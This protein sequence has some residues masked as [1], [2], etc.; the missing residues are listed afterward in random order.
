MPISTDTLFI[1][2]NVEHVNDS[3]QG[4][5]RI[6]NPL[7]TT[8]NGNSFLTSACNAAVATAAQCAQVATFIGN[9]LN[10]R[11][12]RSANSTTGFVRVDFR[13]NDHEAFT[14]SAAV[15]SSRGNN[16]YNNA[17]VATNGGLV[18]ANADLDNTTRYAALG[19]T[20]VIGDHMINDFHGGWFRDS[21]SASTNN[22]QFPASSSACLSCGTGPLGV[23]VDG[24]SLGGNPLMP[25]SQRETRYQGADSFT[26][27]LA[28]HTIRVGGDLWRRQDT[29]D[30]LFSRFG[31]YNYDSL[32]AFAQDFSF[33]V[34][35]LK[36]YATY[37][38]TLGNSSASTTDWLL[39][40][41]AEDTWQVK[42]GFTVT[43]GLRW[44]KARLPKPTEPSG[45]YLTG[46]IPSPNTDVQPRIGLAYMLDR[47]TVVRIGGG[48]YYE[49]FPGQ[50]LHDL[51]LGG[52]N[53]QTSYSLTPAA[54]GTVVF[55]KTL[56]ASAVNTLN[57]ALVG[58]F[59]AAQRFRNPYSLQGSAAIERRLNRWVSL[60]LTYLQSTGQ[61]LW[62]ATDLNLVPGTL[63]D[64]TY[65]INNASGTAV[66]TYATPV[67]NASQ[68]GHHFQVDN[69][70]SSRYKAG[71]VQVRTAPLFGFSVQ[72]AY[73][74]SHAFD[75]MSGPRVQNSIVPSNYFPSSYVGDEGPSLTDQRNHATVNFTSLR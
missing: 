14:L 66:G 60:A 58:E 69:E 31:T 4:L 21:Q 71:I 42:P 23:N 39:S 22:S 6:V 12:P 29:T 11:V 41:Y 16:N 24:T 28:S 13:P 53:F 10:V 52:G 38:Q 32:T 26:I 33:D 49:P 36:N 43:A 74:W 1:F 27:T 59:F 54:T 25:F 35:A 57:P 70:G 61:R 72:A 45:N 64:E 40:V 2:G 9:Q 30:Q 65:T 17:T 48:S 47:R 20:H 46:F 7:L 67:W 75:D 8:P 44:E 68:A 63:T 55:P 34:R 73:T 37:D 15:L 62:T 3:S 56:P 50:L 5:N 19:W 18:G 51:F